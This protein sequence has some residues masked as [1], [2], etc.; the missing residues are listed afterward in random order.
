MSLT[1]G[2]AT[3]PNS[4]TTYL[5]ALFSQS[6]AN[7]RKTLT[8][9]IGA[10]NAVLHEIMQSDSYESA[11]GG[12]HIVEPLMYGLGT[13]DS[14]DGYDELSTLPVDGV[15]QAL[16][17]WRQLA[18]PIAYNMKEVF[19]NQNKLTDLVK[20]K[21]TQAEM[22][23]QEGFA[24]QLLWGAQPAGGAITS[25]RTSAV[26]GSSGITPLPAIVSYSTSGS[27][28]TALTIGGLSE[29]TN[30]WWR[31][32]YKECAAATYAAFILE[33][34]HMYNLCSNGTG[35]P[36]N[37]IL[38]DQVTYELFIHAYFSVYK[39]APDAGGNEY[40]FESKRFLRARVVMD[41]KIPDVYT[42]APGTK[43]GDSVDPS[44]MT[45]GSMYFLNT[46]FLKL[47]YM[48][49][50]DF[51]MLTDENGKTF[52]KPLNGDSRVGHIGWMGELT[53]NKRSKQ[54]VLG[55]IARTLT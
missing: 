37:L 30:S 46:K 35:G 31:N 10:S 24:Q 27:A 43:V 20:T 33:M 3:A 42:G 44:T 18:I 54:G 23:I 49:G 48:P 52:K 32:K 28:G 9:Q 50:R 11:N 53:I 4:L 45:Y 5:D 51:E 7:Y 8:D 16:Y 34:V 41:D 39:T 26:N 22:G 29:Y 36:P 19:Q 40:P 55:K 12:T 15:T 13:M 2:T 38:T 6:L 21:I 14:Y 47:R 17:E 25:P 1:L